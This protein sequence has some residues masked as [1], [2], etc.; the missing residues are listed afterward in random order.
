[1]ASIRKKRVLAILPAI[2]PSTILGVIKPLFELQKQKDIEFRVVLSQLC[3]E[4]SVRQADILVMCRNCTPMD[5]RILFWAKKHCKKIVYEIDD[6]FFKISIET[7]LGRYHR[8]PVRLFILRKIFENSDIIHV[9]SDSLYEIGIRYNPNVKKIRSYFDLSLVDRLTRLKHDGIIKVAYSTSRI[10]QDAVS[11]IYESALRQILETYPHVNAFI[12]GSMPENLKGLTNARLMSYEPNYNRFIRSFYEERFDI[13]LA[14]MLD[15][16]FHRSKTNNKFREYGGCEVAGVYSNVPLYSE[17]VRDGVTGLLVNN[18]EAEW[19]RALERL[20]VDHELRNRIRQNARAYVAN[21]YS[22]D[23]AVATWRQT[24]S[25]VV[26][27]GSGLTSWTSSLCGKSKAAILLDAASENHMKFNPSRLNFLLEAL[28]G[29]QFR[30]THVVIPP[31]TSQKSATLLVDKLEK[32]HDVLV[33]MARGP[34]LRGC[35]LKAA[36]SAMVAFCVDFADDSLIDIAHLKNCQNKKMFVI[37]AQ[38]TEQQSLETIHYIPDLSPT[39][40]ERYYSLDSPVCQWMELILGLR[41]A[42]PPSLFFSD[43][44]SLV[45]SRLMGILK[46]EFTRAYSYSVTLF[47]YA[48][49]VGAVISM[50]LRKRY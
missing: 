32:Q 21:H 24:I 44:I 22:L 33:C 18:S 31:N 47:R 4:N 9:Y 37:S 16:D 42:D 40:R 17:C 27:K 50:N 7:E 10:G 2:I 8:N 46:V 36:A 35:F 38:N 15:D 25:E 5:L 39:D 3:R 49:Q 23:N 29:L 1:M 12:W 48:K 13:G 14:P 41:L 30:K 34:E 6:N 43:S 11:V 26:E 19:R 20:V 45:F 28:D